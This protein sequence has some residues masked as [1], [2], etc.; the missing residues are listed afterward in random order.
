MQLAMRRTLTKGFADFKFERLRMI[1][2]DWLSA[3]C[4]VSMRLLDG[5]G[6]A[7]FQITNTQ[8]VPKM[9]VPVLRG[10]G[11]SHDL[12]HSFGSPIV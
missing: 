8:S 7:A 10:T 9:V 5:L 12:S 1:L 2:T 3:D 4:L 11:D 6:D